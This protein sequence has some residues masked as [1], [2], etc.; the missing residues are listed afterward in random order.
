MAS[1]HRPAAAGW[2]LLCVIG[3][4]TAELFGAH[5]GET[6]RPNTHFIFTADHGAPLPF[7]KGSLYDAGIRVPLITAWPGRLKAGSLSDAM[8]CWPDFF[9]T[10][11]ELASGEV[12]VGPDGKSFAGIL[13]GTTTQRPD[14]P[15]QSVPSL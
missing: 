13:P 11:I 4:W 15:F 3:L 10:F 12:P 6:S 14:P 9:P 2:L 5:A 8:V 7:A 1:P